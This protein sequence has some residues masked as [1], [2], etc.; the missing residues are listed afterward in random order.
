MNEPNAK[1]GR[2][3]TKYNPENYDNFKQFKQ[4]LE[5]EPAAS[6]RKASGYFENLIN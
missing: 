5:D 3:V 4:I 1:S 2:N 6:Q